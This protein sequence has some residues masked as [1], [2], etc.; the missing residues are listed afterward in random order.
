MKLGWERRECEMNRELPAKLEFSES[1]RVRAA[2]HLAKTVYPGAVGRLLSRELYAY[3]E[4]G[5]RFPADG[6][7]EQVVREV[8]GECAGPPS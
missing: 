3:A 4:F 6:L 1:S 5:L 8:L 2:A 7:T